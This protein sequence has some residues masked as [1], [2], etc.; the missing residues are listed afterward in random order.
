MNYLIK[1]TTHNEFATAT[2]PALMGLSKRFSLLR[3][4]T[5]RY[6]QAEKK[7]Q[8]QNDNEIFAA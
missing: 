2:K 5:E 3:L 4:Q 6:K 1:S 8:R 7:R